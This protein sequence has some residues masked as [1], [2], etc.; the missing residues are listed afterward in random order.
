MHQIQTGESLRELRTDVHHLKDGRDHET[1]VQCEREE[2]ADRH[3]LPDEQPSTDDH[4]RDADNAHQKRRCKADD[5]LSK[6]RPSNVF[7]KS[8]GAGFKDGRFAVFGV[9]ALDDPHA[10]KRLGQPAGDFSIDLAP[11][12]EDRADRSQRF[13]KDRAKD[14]QKPERN[15]G[16]R[17]VDFEEQ[18]K[19]NYAGEKAADE[20]HEARTNEVSDTF[21]IRHDS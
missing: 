5:R 19:C 12:S 16:E 17:R 21:D 2:I 20:F 1:K 18:R 6:K 4:Y 13:L 11:L 3:A 8:D 9:K 10:A 14:T 15:D 7:K